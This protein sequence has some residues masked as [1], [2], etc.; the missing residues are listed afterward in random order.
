MGSVNG[1]MRITLLG[2]GSAFPSTERLQS[3]IL[4]ER[5]GRRLLVDCGSG[6][7]HRLKQAGFDHTDVSTVL[8]THHHLDHVA[9]LPTL[10]K[11]R[12]LAD[13]P[14]ISIIGPPGTSDVCDR[15]FAHDNLNE[16][17]TVQVEEFPADVD[18]VQAAGIPIEPMETTHA[19]PSFAFR[20]AGNAVISGDT[21]PDPAV[22]ELADGCH[23]LIHECSFPDG[24]EV[25]THTTPAG[26][27]D[28]VEAIDVER[29]VITH[30]F[31][32]AEAEVERIRTKLVA[33]ID[34]SVYVG[35]DGMQVAVPE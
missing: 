3:G 34:G 33:S 20:L 5:D 12:I 14:D 23:T 28:G 4:I 31:P 7:L 35:E 18:T 16:R 24:T 17:G 6:V 21:A 9:D 10:F 29:L 15:L 25:E 11:A 30:L 13:H 1:D 8:L 2:T 22:F 27:I 19:S 32:R 26:L